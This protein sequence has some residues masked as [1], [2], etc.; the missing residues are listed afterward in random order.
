MQNNSL[1]RIFGILFGVVSIYQL[2]FTF[3]TSQ[4]EEKAA[5]YAAA[6]IAETTDNYVDLRDKAEANYLDSIGNVSLFGFT[7]YNDAKKKE[8]NKG[9]DLKGGIN[10]ILQI[11][12]REVLKGLVASNPP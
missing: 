10:V 6:T 2:S 12:I 1:I 11:S 7:T 9:L 5:A 8:L 3:I 4:Q